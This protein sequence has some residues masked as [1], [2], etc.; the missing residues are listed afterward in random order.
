MALRRV[1][2]CA[3]VGLAALPFIRVVIR[4]WYSLYCR[5]VLTRT[6][7]GYGKDVQRNCDFCFPSRAIMNTKGSVQGLCARIIAKDGDL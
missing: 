6:S 5:A 3:L 4:Q 7:Q 2:G 1:D